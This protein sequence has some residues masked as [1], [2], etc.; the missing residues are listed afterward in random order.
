MTA[1][2]FVGTSGS[3][4]SIS[5][6]N[7]IVGEL[8]DATGVTKAVVWTPI[9]TTAADRTDYNAPVMLSGIPAK[10]AVG[11]TPAVPALDGD[12][13]AVAITGNKVLGEITDTAT[14]E[15]HAVVWNGILATTIPQDRGADTIAGG[16]SAAGRIVGTAGGN[17]AL[18]TGL[19][20]VR[21][22]VGAAPAVSPTANGGANAINNGNK[23]VGTGNGLA[24]FATP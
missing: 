1:G 16:M 13:T 7:V 18:M 6:T 3:A 11:T 19:E 17:A 2:T 10:P 8:T 5:A 4:F 15:I 20:P 22:H 14:G 23:A 9:T 21:L 24:F 12:S